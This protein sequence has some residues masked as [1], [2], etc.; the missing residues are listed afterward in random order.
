[1]YKSVC[2]VLVLAVAA[3]ARKP[4]AGTTGATRKPLFVRSTPDGQTPSE[5]TFCTDYYKGVS[6]RLYGLCNSYCEAMDCDSHPKVVG[7]ACFSVGHLLANVA[8]DVFHEDPE[9]INP[10]DTCKDSDHDGHPDFLDNCPF[11]PNADQA[12]LD[13]D[14]VGDVCDNCPDDYNPGQEDSNGNGIG[15]VCD[16]PCFATW[17]NGIGNDALLPTGSN[18]L[19]G[20]TC[21]VR[22][23]P[24]P[25]VH[26]WDENLYCVEN[27]NPTTQYY[28]ANT[29]DDD[30]G[31]CEDTKAGVFDF[32]NTQPF[33][34]QQAQVCWSFFTSQGATLDADTDG[35]RVPDSLDN[36]PL[37]SNFN[38]A[39]SDE[40]A[41]FVCGAGDGIG[42]A[43]DSIVCGDC[44][45]QGT[46]ECDAGSSP[47]NGNANVADRC[48]TNCRL[49]VCGDGIRDSGEQCDNGGGNSNA[50]NAAC[51]TN[52]RNRR[53]GD[54]I[55]DTNFGEECEPP[56][57]TGCDAQCKD[58][59][60]NCQDFCRQVEGPVFNDCFDT[61]DAQCSGIFVSQG[62]LDQEF[63]VS[64]VNCA[65]EVQC[66]GNC[67]NQFVTLIR[68]GSAQFP[69]MI[70]QAEA[71][72]CEADLN[73]N[74]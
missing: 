59:S 53:C 29:Q 30:P 24:N 68:S 21:F 67:D 9:L 65:Y 48:R 66:S 33:T 55:V 27:T 69:E 73:I 42:D 58:D 52:C 62:V 60:F 64:T 11:H 34:L 17:V 28:L 37:V 4:L 40:D 38:Q 2:F 5:E 71:D 14:S 16:C 63:T 50:P 20:Y 13:G 35:D 39:D 12:D 57:S 72:T 25:P 44:V 56:S 41:N 31:Y 54:G 74:F 18:Q 23:E 45:T 22:G 19:G 70:T 61:L 1:M 51:R 15:D 3:L 32:A 6:G 36:C 46:E 43:C 8:G 49:P 7:A 47:I 26:I 10:N